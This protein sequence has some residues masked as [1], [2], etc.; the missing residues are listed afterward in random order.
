M[1]SSY[2]FH[3]IANAYPLMSE[4]EFNNLVSSMEEKG[5]DR[6]FPI[7]L[8]EGKILD[9]RNRYL[10][11][12]EAKVEPVF[13]IFEGTFDEAV[14]E[15]R[16]L[17]SCRRNLGKC[18]KAMVAAKDILLTRAC[19][20]KKLSVKK[21]SYIYDVSEGYIK[22]AMWIINEDR[23]LADNVFEGK[24]SLKEAEYRANEIKRLRESTSDDLGQG[25]TDTSSIE[26]SSPPMTS[27]DD[28]IIS[29]VQNLEEENKKLKTKLSFYE[30]L[31][32]SCDKKP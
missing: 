4:K 17:N 7:K 3:P 22:L 15:S 20:G 5:F 32:E 18:Q 30:N 16:R 23:Q 12:F 26:E 9:G 25:L 10:S 24:M 28:E 19:D 8:Y 29:Q 6:N 13:E 21:A 2:E 31:C 27:I 14:C 11:A 1:S